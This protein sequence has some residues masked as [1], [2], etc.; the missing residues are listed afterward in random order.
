M[1]TITKNIK[2]INL[3][4]SGFYVSFNNDIGT[5]KAGTD[6]YLQLPSNAEA[7]HDVNVDD[8]TIELCIEVIGFSDEQLS[9]MSILNSAS[10]TDVEVKQ[11][12]TNRHAIQLKR[13][14]N[15][16]NIMKYSITTIQFFPCATTEQ[17]GEN[18]FI[19]SKSYGA[20]IAINDSFIIQ[21][22]GDLDKCDW[23]I[24]ESREA[25]W[26]NDESQDDACENI[27]KDELIAFLEAEGVE[28]N[29]FWLEENCNETY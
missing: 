22:S 17:V 11:V 16:V 19:E 12:A 28:N 2:A 3:D 27:D 10:I 23:S 13:T 5:L 7:Q 1:T 29:Y 15:G 4:D 9:I 6:I 18:E 21:L 24:P 25:K 20:N 8:E 26:N 14:T